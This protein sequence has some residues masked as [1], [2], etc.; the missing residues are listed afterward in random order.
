V[1]L[2]ITLTVSGKLVWTELLNVTT[3]M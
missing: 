2:F 1:N 3:D